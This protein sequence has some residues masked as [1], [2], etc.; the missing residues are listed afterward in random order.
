MSVA[1]GVG[2]GLFFASLIYSSS[3][4]RIIV[5]SSQSLH[6]ALWLRCGVSCASAGRFRLILALRFQSMRW[7]RAAAAALQAGK[8]GAVCR[9]NPCVRGRLG[10]NL[11]WSGPGYASRPLP[12]LHRSAGGRRAKPQSPQKNR[13]SSSRVAA[14]VLHARLIIGCAA[15]VAHSPCSERLAAARARNTEA[16]IGRDPQPQPRKCRAACRRERRQI[17]GRRALTAA[18]AQQQYYKDD[19]PDRHGFGRSRRL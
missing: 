4:P 11:R 13:E 15:F 18:H 6:S 7:P 14:A 19:P 1:D 10:P 3:L 5:V 8:V 17:A 16:R 2:H 9:K 12:I